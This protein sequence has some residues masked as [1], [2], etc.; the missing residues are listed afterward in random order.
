VTSIIHE[1]HESSRIRTEKDL[2]LA[3]EVY[4]IV[5]AAFEVY[6]EL[7][8]GFLESVYQEALEI[9]L[10]SR[11]ISFLSQPKLKITYKGQ[12]LQKEYAP[13]L[14]VMDS[15]IVE[16]KALDQ[17]TPREEAQVINYLKATGKKVGLL[18]NFGSHPKLQWMR[19]V[20]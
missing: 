14:I 13:D 19:R 17:L 12:L 11:G 7:G 18:I 20:L 3:D 5:G 16:L 6:N 4:A 10:R 15:V 2:P 1:L 9:E 8:T